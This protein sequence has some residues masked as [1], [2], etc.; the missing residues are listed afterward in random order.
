[1]FFLVCFVIFSIFFFSLETR[2]FC[3][4]LFL[5][6]PFRNHGANPMVLTVVFVDDSRVTAPCPRS[7]MDPTRR[8]GTFCPMVSW[9]SVC[10]TSTIWTFFLCTT[11]SLLLRLPTRFRL[12][13]GS[14]LLSGLPNWMFKWLTRMP[15]FDQRSST[16]LII[17]ENKNTSTDVEL[18]LL[19]YFLCMFNL[20]LQHLLEN[21]LTTRFVQ[22]K[23]QW[24][25]HKYQPH[26]SML[27]PLN[28]FRLLMS[29][30][31]YRFLDNPHSQE[32]RQSTKWEN[33]KWKEKS[34][35]FKRLEYLPTWSHPIKKKRSNKSHLKWDCEYF[36]KETR[37]KKDKNKKKTILKTH[38]VQNNKSF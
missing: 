4:V 5:N 7:V 33:K 16:K 20:Q 11:R 38:M 24:F 2:W 37:Q 22:C 8:P 34:K 26:Q 18:I 31:R 13:R 32:H 25:Q 1:M 14:K 6:S 10:T 9:S 19:N 28:P 12:K 21:V 29:L 35:S 23:E 36:L 17:L 27:W 30:H 15:V 3:E